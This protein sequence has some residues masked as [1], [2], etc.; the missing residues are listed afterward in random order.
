MEPG[1]SYRRIWPPTPDKKL[2]EAS[3]TATI[4]REAFEPIPSKHDRADEPGRPP[5]GR[6]KAATNAEHQPAPPRHRGRET[7]A[8]GYTYDLQQDL[9]NRAGLAR[10][11]YGPR[12]R[13]LTREDDHQAQRDRHNLTRAENRIRTSSELCRDVLPLEHV[14]VFP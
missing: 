11:I 5:R 6:D 9:D 3:A 8:P 12:G 7:A 2:S 13:A 4:Q 10:S 14:L 1:P